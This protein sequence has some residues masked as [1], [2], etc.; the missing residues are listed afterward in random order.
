MTLVVK[1]GGSVITDK[2]TPETVDEANLGRAADA[3]AG[4]DDMVVVHGAGSFGHHY[5]SKHGV[6]D[7]EGSHSAVA[8]AEINGT[9]K[10]L[11]GRVVAALQERDVPAV[12][13]HPFS[14]AH[15]DAAGETTHPTDHLACMLG[16]GFVPVLHGD[17]VTQADAGVTIISGDELVVECA[18]QLGAERVGLCSAVPGVYD[19][20]ERVVERVTA[21]EEMAAALGGSDATDVTGGMAGK[22]RTLLDLDVPASIFDLD[23]LP[24][25]LAGERPGTTID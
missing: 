18:R 20:D 24:A 9:M 25:F 23:H 13:V 8:A 14:F 11:N 17:V 15:R 6:T 1:L 10:E 22:V 2:A 16:E 7:T 3:L 5:A 19:Q 21:F 12:P 4:R